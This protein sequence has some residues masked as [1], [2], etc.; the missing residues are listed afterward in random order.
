MWEA[1]LDEVAVLSSIYCGE[2]EFRLITNSAQDG[3]LIQIKSSV[4]GDKGADV[5]LLFHLHP[6]Y[7]S[8]P[9]DISVSSTALS[10]NQ[11]HNIRHKLLEHAAT[12]PPEA[13]VHQLVLFLQQCVETTEEHRG[14][15]E[16]RR[17]DSSRQEWTTVLT[18]DHI[19]SRNRY[20][21]LLERW[22]QQLCLAGRL[23]LGRPIVLILHG[24]QPDVKE[25]CRLL[26]TVKVDVDSSGRKCKERMMKIISESP[27]S[28]ANLH[29]LQG[30]VTK[31]FSSVSELS[32]AFQ[33][34]GLT[35]IYQQILSSPH[36]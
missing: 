20:I 3:L 9:P 6:R 30:F 4:G 12:L 16:E 33:E 35:E 25:F 2:E 26:K 15:E 1:A 11:C 32:A 31:D 10:R 7:P 14:V 17:E 24:D 18:L 22:S 13:M 28:S 19:R 8:S 21:G 27:S 36:S 5:S 23:F 34:I 29:R